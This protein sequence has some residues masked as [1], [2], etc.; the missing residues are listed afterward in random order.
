M[1]YIVF[2]MCDAKKKHIN[3]M[4]DNFIAKQMAMKSKYFGTM[5]VNAQLHWKFLSIAVIYS[6]IFN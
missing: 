2:Y 3:R 1:S 4:I 5:H 6:I